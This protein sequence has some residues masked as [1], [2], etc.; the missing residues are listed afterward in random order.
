MNKKTVYSLLFGFIT[1]ALLLGA[2][3]LL[4]PSSQM[5]NEQLADNGLYVFDPPRV[6]N[7][8]SLQD[9]NNNPIDSALFKDKWSLLF[10]GYTYCP[11][12][13]PLTMASL[14]QFYGLLEDSGEYTEDTQI[15]MVSVDPQRDT[16]EKLSEYIGFFNNDFIG[17]RGEYINIFTFAS[18]LN[19]AFAYEPGGG[20][21]YLVS[22]NGEIVLINP[23]GQ[24]H[25]FFKVPHDPEKMAVNYAAVRSAWD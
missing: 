13:C 8:F 2:S 3:T 23:D 6:L 1:L 20:E 25:G 24:Y 22:H 15:I 12:I 17:L 19:I 21:D 7:E 16:P 14:N 10:F 18:Q 4:L 5:T 9:H 11:D